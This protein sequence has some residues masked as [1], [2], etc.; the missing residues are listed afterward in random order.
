[1]LL[2][3]LDIAKKSLGMQRKLVLL[4]ETASAETVEFQYVITPRLSSL[5]EIVEPE[6]KCLFLKIS[7]SKIHLTTMYH[8]HLVER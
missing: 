5:K 4:L 8:C 2:L 3:N 7:S 1:M 6:I